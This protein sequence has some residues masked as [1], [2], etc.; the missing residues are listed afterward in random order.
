MDAGSLAE[1]FGSMPSKKASRF[2][3][4]QTSIHDAE[5]ECRLFVNDRCGEFLP[6]F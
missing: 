6:N 5:R 1:R 3:G 2:A 4:S